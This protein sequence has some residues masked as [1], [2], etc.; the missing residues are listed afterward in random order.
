MSSG[1]EPIPIKLGGET[2]LATNMDTLI[3]EAFR[4][5]WLSARHW[6]NHPLPEHLFV[7]IEPIQ[8]PGPASIVLKIEWP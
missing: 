5:G 3:K 6:P 8:E 1:I 7:K 4:Q 2:H